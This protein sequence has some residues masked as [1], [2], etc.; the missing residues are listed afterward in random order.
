MGKQG[1]GQLRD[2]G[3]QQRRRRQGEEVKFIYSEKAKNFCEISTLL[4][5]FVVPVKS[6]VDILQ[7]F[8]AFIEYMNFDM[9]GT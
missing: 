7:K 4:L 6:K 2:R 9:V 3:G 1:E 8:V 5:C